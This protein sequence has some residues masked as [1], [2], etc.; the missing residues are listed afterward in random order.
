MRTIN[1]L[2]AWG[3]TQKGLQLFGG[4]KVKV[5]DSVLLDNM[6][7][8]VYVTSSDATAAGQRPVADRSRHGR[9]SGAQ[10]A[11]GARSA[12]TPTW[13]GSAWR[14]RAG[15]GTL[16][17]SA[18]GNVFAG[19]TDCAVVDRR[20]SSARRSC[21]GCVDLGDRRRRGHDRH[22]RPRDLPV[23]SRRRSRSAR[24]AGCD[25]RG[26]ATARR[27]RRSRRGSRDGRA[28]SAAGRH[29]RAVA[30]LDLRRPAGC[31]RGFPGR[32]PG[33]CRRRA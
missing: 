10:P 8:G 30:V 2:V 29:R 24:L 4:E 19:P 25:G 7:N 11:A 26:T 20:R 15:Q 31:R 12:R 21:G 23:A 1:G 16:T 27:R 13:P 3:N 33:R 9:R 14:C 6:L 32:S 17:L 28:G 18:E 5:R 22:R